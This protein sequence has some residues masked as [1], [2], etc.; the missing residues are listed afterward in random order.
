MHGMPEQGA[1]MAAAPGFEGELDAALQMCDRA[2]LISTSAFERG[3]RVSQKP[4]GTPVT[5]ADTEIETMIRGTLAERFPE[6]GIIGEEFGR[7]DPAPREWIIDPIDGT[8]N[9]AA[10][11]PLWSTLLGL[12][13]DGR[14]VVGVVSLPGIG[15]RYW[16]AEG[17]GAFGDG[18]PIGVS[19]V[20]DTARAMVLFGDI[21]PILSSPVEAPFLQIIR[22]A[23]RS[24][25]F[26]DAWGYGLIAAGKAEVMIEPMGM[27]WDFAAPAAVVAAAGGTMT[28]F[29]GSPL[30]DG[31][32]A[33]ASNGVL[34]QTYVDALRPREGAAT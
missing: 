31:G 17:V 16:G 26:G 9:Y 8:K 32:S 1:E 11:I 23:R 24:R 10:G 29:D 14:F 19:R 4:D 30:V 15:K 5:D 34:H 3:P 13:V 6:D 20:A 25:G 7:S 22:G 21:E 2:D 33:L 18:T 27:I 28:Q 12:R